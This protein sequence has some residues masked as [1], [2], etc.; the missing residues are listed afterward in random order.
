MFC[1]SI[2]KQRSSDSLPQYQVAVSSNGHCP[3][4]LVRAAFTSLELCYCLGSVG[5]CSLWW[6]LVG[7]CNTQLRLWFAAE[8]ML[9]F[10]LVV[11]FRLGARSA[12]CSDIP[13]FLQSS[14]SS[15]IKVVK[16]SWAVLLPLEIAL[17][18]RG[19]SWFSQ[20]LLDN[21]EDPGAEMGCLADASDASNA[22]I[23]VTIGFFGLFSIGYAVFCG[24]VLW[25]THSLRKAQW[26]LSKVYDD[27]MVNRWGNQPTLLASDMSGLEIDSIMS[28]GVTTCATNTCCSICLDNICVGDQCRILP[29]GHTFHRPCL[30]LWLIRQTTCPMCKFDC[31]PTLDDAQSG[32][33]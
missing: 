1:R 6:L 30:D 32:C 13:W 11:T 8:I 31:K 28:L 14:E 16:R 29:C 23:A 22:L 5:L 20:A 15:N 24:N 17:A 2:L 18:E 10:L 26:Q 27:E 7:R 12:A 3:G 25:Y 33:L 9:L 21:L 19:A 4:S